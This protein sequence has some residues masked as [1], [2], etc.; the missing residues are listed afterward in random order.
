MS[1]IH[2]RRPHHQRLNYVQ[3]G[4]LTNT[5]KQARG[6]VRLVMTEVEILGILGANSFCFW[7]E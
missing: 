5:R 2:H 7:V 6:L 3:R 4:T 1:Q